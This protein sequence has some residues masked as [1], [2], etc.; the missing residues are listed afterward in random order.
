MT[1]RVKPDGIYMISG[2]VPAIAEDF[3]RLSTILRVID[4]EIAKLEHPDY[5][6]SPE[7]AA[8]SSLRARFEES[9]DEI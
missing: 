5:D 6:T 4:E 7:V 1:E 9:T 2:G 8:L 3:Y